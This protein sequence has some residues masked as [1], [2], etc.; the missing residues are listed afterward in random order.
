MVAP[1]IL[2][3]IVDNASVVK[4]GKTILNNV[5]CTIGQTGF[6]IVMGPNGAGKTSLLRLMHGLER[7]N[8][9]SVSW[10]LPDEEA[11]TKQ[12]FVFQTPVLMRRTA[13]ENIAYPAMLRGQAAPTARESA[14]LLAAKVGI[15]AMQ[16]MDARFLSGGERQKLA[17]ARAL[18]S[19]PNILFLD[20]PT[21]NLDGQSTKE[22][23]LILKDIAQSG[24]RL[25]MTTHDIGQARRLASEVIFLN[26]GVICEQTSAES[27]FSHPQSDAAKAYL[28]GDILE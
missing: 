2:P 21:A 25:V 24:T 1:S 22:I 11:R 19:Q 18:I 3:L 20:E 23:E 27:F 9:G 28:Q 7:P 4:R 14:A 13:L 17:L 8:K 16:N 26:R 15:G 6:T 5:S 12:G 10:H